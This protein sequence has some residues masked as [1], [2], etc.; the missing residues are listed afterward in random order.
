[1]P[2][3]TP[4]KPTATQAKVLHLLAAGPQTLREV[5]QQLGQTTQIAST[6]QL[7]G[8]M[9]GYGWIEP[10]EQP[11]DQ[12]RP[13]RTWYLCSPGARLIAAKRPRIQPV[14]GGAPP[15]TQSPTPKQRAILATLNNYAYL[16]FDQI[17]EDTGNGTGERALQRRLTRLRAAGWIAEHLLHPERGHSSPRYW[18]LLPAGGA[19]LGIPF[20]PAPPP[21]LATVQADLSPNAAPLPPVSP[22]DHAILALL[23]EW[24]ALQTTHIG[25]TLAPTT[26][27]EYTKKRLTTLAQTGFIQGTA[28]PQI[29]RG[30]PEYYW[31]LRPA[32][33]ALLQIPYDKQYRRR[34]TTGQLHQ[35]G[36]LLTLRAACTSAGGQLLCPQPSGPA[37]PAVE[38]PAQYQQLKKAVLEYERIT[39]NTMIAEGVH[40][41]YIEGRVTRY[42]AGLTGGVVPTFINDYV[43]YHPI[44]VQHTIV[45]I[46]HPPGAGPYFWTRRR[47]Q[48]QKESTY[49]PSRAERYGRLA[50]ILP[51]IAVFSTEEEAQEYAPILHGTGLHPLAL[52]CL[53]AVLTTLYAGQPVAW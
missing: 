45:L 18:I 29:K 5:W 30:A 26:N 52:D 42:R 24:K 22:S 38:Y 40:R 48:H 7:L 44:N 21:A 4:T 19:A 49:S 41:D 28:L 43:A 2:A 3:S 11:D 34:P 37:H 39:I 23:A 16:T 50:A 51:V 46:P 1:M 25:Q 10:R 32:G 8:R 33:A 53:T 35:R 14:A 15:N 36:V 13:T 12:G 47:K 27:Y 31:T 9:K 6:A 17:A 20:A